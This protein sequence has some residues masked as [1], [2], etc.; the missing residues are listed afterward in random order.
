MSLH[1]ILWSNFGRYDWIIFAVALINAGIFVYTLRLTK[2]MYRS[3]YSG[4]FRALLQWDLDSLIRK[5]TSTNL[6]ELSESQ[7]RSEHWY[8]FYV[9]MT[10]IFP[11]LGILG[12]V[13]S[14]LPIVAD[15]S[16]TQQSFFAALTSTFWGLVFAILFKF[17]DSFLSPHIED[18]DKNVTLFLERHRP[19]G[20]AVRR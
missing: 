15:L 17:I 2:K 4:G 19:S 20:E 7:N 9:N 6:E 1:S 16:D 10:A 5:L 8:S 13:L 12:T 14:L 18:N 11:L 3:I